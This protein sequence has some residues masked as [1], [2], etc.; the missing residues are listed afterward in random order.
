[1]GPS[2]RKQFVLDTNVLLDLAAG[3]EFAHD[4]KD[5][6][7]AHGYELLVPPTALFELN[8]LTREHDAIRK[9]RAGRALESLVQ[10]KCQPFVL[11]ESDTAIAMRFRQTLSDLELIPDDEWNDGLVLAEASIEGVPFVVTSDKHLLNIDEDLLQV[12]FV[13]S[14]L[15]SV[16]VVSPRRLLRAFR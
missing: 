7:Q 9:A 4:F 14:G 5:V 6:F 2:P 11:S 8:N 1:M 10:W 15:P 12:A 3:A 13:R 16:H